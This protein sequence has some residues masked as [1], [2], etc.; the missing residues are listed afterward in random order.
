[1]SSPA[2]D[3]PDAVSGSMRGPRGWQNWQARRDGQ[4]AHSALEYACYTDAALHGSMEHDFGPYRLLNTLA[5]LANPQPGRIQLALVLRVDLHLDETDEPQLP[6][7]MRVPDDISETGNRRAMDELFAGWTDTTTYHGGQLDDEMA[8]LASLALGVRLKSGGPIREFRPDNPDPRG[9]PIGF[10]HW[11]PYL[12]SSQN[13]RG[14]VLPEA[15]AGAELAQVA[16]PLTRYPDLPA[17]QAVALV[18]AARIYQEGLWIAEDDPR[19]AWLRF[20]SAA[21]VAADYWAVDRPPEEQL[22]IARPNLAALLAAK[23]D[24]HL[25][26]VA[27]LLTAISGSTS[28]FIRF[29]I[30]FAPDPPRER[31]SEYQQVD[32]SSRT[33]LR[34]HLGLIYDYRSKD[35]HTGTPMPQP[36]CEPPHQDEGSPPSEI[37]LGPWTW[38][39]PEPAFWARKDTPMLLHV[40]AGIVRRALLA[41]WITEGQE[42]ATQG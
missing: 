24:D 2:P 31:P 10:D 17:G 38:I 8:A 14:L 19:Q 5:T 15:A 37:P 6:P 40:F 4:P 32:W 30:R 22:R 25:R 29:L 1:M 36:M 39:G 16:A 23:G 9:R 7:P 33:R 13:P 26:E 41:W 28:K 18:R 27:A 3:T 34:D 42:K 35:L 20:V 21:E 11:P 12:P